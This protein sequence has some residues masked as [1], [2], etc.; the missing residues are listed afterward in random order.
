MNDDS[1]TMTVAS[2]DGMRGTPLLF[3]VAK[4]RRDER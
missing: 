4:L 2:G 1:A 3:A